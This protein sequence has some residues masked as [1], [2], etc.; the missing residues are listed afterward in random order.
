MVREPKGMAMSYMTALLVGVSL[1]AGAAVAA[2]SDI[3]IT[4]IMN[5]PFVLSDADG[6]WFEVYN[7]GGTPVDLNGWTISDLGTNTH[8]IAGSAVV[9]AGGYAVLGIN[10]AAM[11]SEGVTLLPSPTGT[12][13]SFSP[14]LLRLRSTG[15]NTTAAPSGPIRPALR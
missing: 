8:T 10:A 12:M 4:E 5:N 13:K 11:A 2:D 1:L 3:V 7:G 6:E 14:T 9:P 15:S